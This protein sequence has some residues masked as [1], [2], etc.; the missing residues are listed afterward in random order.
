L[1]SWVGLEGREGGRRPQSSRI[2]VDNDDGGCGAAYL[3]PVSHS[4]SVHDPGRT[5]MRGS[6]IFGRPRSRSW[7]MPRTRGPATEIMGKPRTATGTYLFHDDGLR[8]AMSSRGISDIWSPQTKHG[9]VKRRNILMCVD[10]LYEPTSGPV[11]NRDH[12]KSPTAKQRTRL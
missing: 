3:S 4:L 1:F 8:G 7:M 2:G 10:I 9:C 12:F 11:R 5:I 6:Q